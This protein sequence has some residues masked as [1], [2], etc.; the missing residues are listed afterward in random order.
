MCNFKSTITVSPSYKAIWESLGLRSV[1]SISRHFIKEGIQNKTAVVVKPAR[2]FISESEALDVFYKQYEYQ[3]PTW[4][5]FGRP[6]KARREFTNYAHFSRLTIQCADPIACGEERDRFGRLCRA[7]ILTRAVPNSETLIQFLSEGKATTADRD[8]IRKQLANLMRL[9][10]E[11][12]FYHNDIYF[13]NILVSRNGD[14]LTQLSLIDCPRGSYSTFLPISNHRQIKDIAAIDRD[15]LKYCKR[16]DRLCFI[17]EYLKIDKLN[18]NS[19]KII[20]RIEY[21]RHNRW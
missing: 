18:N 13:R 17:K 1:C 15:A 5:F 2:L 10:H 3:T 21:Y 9:M 4:K 8:S 19:K 11:A 16:K 20:S 7:F 14:G 12:K 6:S